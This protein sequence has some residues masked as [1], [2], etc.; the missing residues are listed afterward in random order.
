MRVLTLIAAGILGLGLAAGA[1][2]AAPEALIATGDFDFYILALSWSPGF[3]DTGGAEKAR[4]QCAAGA[5]Q[6]F[7]VHGLWP[8]NADRPYPADCG[9][10]GFIPGAALATHGLYP[11][12]GLARYEFRKHGTCTGLSPENYF[13]AVKFARDEIAIPPMLQAPHEAPFHFAQSEIENAF[14]AANPK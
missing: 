4:D 11:D 2:A 5:G 14:I 13:A 3:C 1:R 6:G 10:A 9:E 8:E 12:E 7:V